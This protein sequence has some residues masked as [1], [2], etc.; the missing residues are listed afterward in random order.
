MLR[1]FSS[2]GISR[3]WLILIL[4]FCKTVQRNIILSHHYQL[5][6]FQ[7]AL[8]SR[9]NSDLHSNPIYHHGYI[10]LTQVEALYETECKHIRSF[11]QLYLTIIC[12][13]KECSES[14]SKWKPWKCPVVSKHTELEDGAGCK[15]QHCSKAET[16]SLFLHL[17]LFQKQQKPVYT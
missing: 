8:T 6:I 7:G 11:F 15:A 13:I 14:T 12:A 4:F 2:L 17:L 10:W 5:Q 3:C 16:P 1:V 9:L